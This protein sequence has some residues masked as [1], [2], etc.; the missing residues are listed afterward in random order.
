M[1]KVLF[2]ITHYVTVI[3]CEFRTF[4]KKIAL[5]CYT[6]RLNNND[7]NNNNNKNININN[8]KIIIIACKS[9]MIRD[10]IIH[11]VDELM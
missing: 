7:N 4:I 1:R 8:K 5:K 10:Q 9:I 11:F 3:I 6:L 2:I